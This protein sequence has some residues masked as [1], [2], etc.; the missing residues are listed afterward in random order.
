MSEGAGPKLD[1]QLGR[2]CQDCGKVSKGTHKD[3]ESESQQQQCIVEFT[4]C[5]R[6]VHFQRIPATLILS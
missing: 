1:R 4:V 2:C 5:S 3:S 6:D